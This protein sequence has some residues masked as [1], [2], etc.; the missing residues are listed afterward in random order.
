MKR[1]PLKFFLKLSDTD[2]S[3]R[4]AGEARERRPFKPKRMMR[5]AGSGPEIEP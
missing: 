1:T 4:Q 5:I 3:E 2:Y